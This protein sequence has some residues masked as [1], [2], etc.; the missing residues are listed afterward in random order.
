MTLGR[1]VLEFALIEEH[2]NEHVR[3]LMISAGQRLRLSKAL[4]DV[5]FGVCVDSRRGGE[6]VY[7]SIVHDFMKSEVASHM[8]SVALDNRLSMTVPQRH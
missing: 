3:S 6:G 7:Q 5:R 2:F 8:R 1:F 4:V